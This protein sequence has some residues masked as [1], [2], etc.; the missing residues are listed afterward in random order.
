MMVIYMDKQNVAIIALETVGLTHKHS[1]FTHGNSLPT[2]ILTFCAIYSCTYNCRI[3]RWFCVCF[4]FQAELDEKAKVLVHELFKQTNLATNE[5]LLS[6][7]KSIP[8]LCATRAN[9]K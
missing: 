2:C 1:R 5:D 3:V 4:S 8:F 6:K 9:S 7:M